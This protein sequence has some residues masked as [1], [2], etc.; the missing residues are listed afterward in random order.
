MTNQE[1]I[2]EVFEHLETIDNNNYNLIKDQTRKEFHDYMIS[3]LDKHDYDTSSIEENYFTN[4][5]ISYMSGDCCENI[6]DD[7]ISGLKK[8]E[9]RNI[10]LKIIK[11]DILEC[12][13]E[14]NIK[15]DVVS[16]GSEMGSISID[17]FDVTR[18]CKLYDNTLFY[19]NYTFMEKGM[20]H[21][22][23]RA[24]KCKIVSNM[25][26]FPV[27]LI[28]MEE[29]KV[30]KYLVTHHSIK[31]PLNQT[32][33]VDG[34]LLFVIED[35]NEKK[36]ISEHHT[37]VQIFYKDMKTCN[38]RLKIENDHI[39]FLGYK[40]PLLTKQIIHDSLFETVKEEYGTWI[41][42]EDDLLICD[43]YIMKITS[44]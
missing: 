9:P 19:T 12:Y 41:E 20:L 35:L 29:P 17:K 39:I 23:L 13:I 7:I 6:L 22:V 27:E 11:K 14:M 31:I 38:D 5:I 28:I 34:E 32:S 43:I 1:I 2:D 8:R 21:H 15:G 37:E 25:A 30:T 33:H 24:D 40:Y 44:K 10:K 18:R 3:L 26:V 42:L 16:F 36:V 4:F